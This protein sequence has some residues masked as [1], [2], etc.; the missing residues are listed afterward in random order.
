MKQVQNRALAGAVTADPPLLIWTRF[1][2]CLLEMWY[3]PDCCL[4]LL[5]CLI[6]RVFLFACLTIWFCCYYC[7]NYLFILE[8]RVTEAELSSSDSLLR[9]P[10]QLRLGQ[11][12][13]RSIVRVPHVDGGAPGSLPSS[14]AS[15]RSY[16]AAMEQP[17]FGIAIVSGN[18]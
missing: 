7:H 6:T 2:L 15:T 16:G 5:Q 18:G 9:Q 4:F 1:C 13:A 11:A 3:I 14:S 8:V 10:Q 12:K 17:G